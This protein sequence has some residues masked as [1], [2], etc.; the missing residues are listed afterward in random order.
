MNEAQEWVKGKSRSGGTVRDVLNEIARRATGCSAVGTPTEI[1]GRLEI[2]RSTFYW[3]MWSLEKMGELKTGK[4]AS[5]KMKLRVYHMQAFCQFAEN[6]CPKWK[7]FTGQWV[8]SGNPLSSLEQEDRALSSGL[9]LRKDCPVCGNR[10]ASFVVKATQLPLFQDAMTMQ[11]AK[12]VCSL[13][14]GTGWRGTVRDEDG[15]LSGPLAP[16]D[17][18]AARIA[19][20]WMMAEDRL[21]ERLNGQM[22]RSRQQAAI[23]FVAPK[24]L[25]FPQGEP[26]SGLTA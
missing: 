12:E 17:H 5:S 7:K 10:A 1:I 8:S 3:A 15:E 18:F 14:N 9:I 25:I 23:D 2:S 26:W 24:E 21:V 6:H 4:L 22:I 19:G 20:R 16:C 11:Q 13:C